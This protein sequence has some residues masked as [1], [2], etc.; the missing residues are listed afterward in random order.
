[1][2]K[3]IAGP[4][5]IPSAVANLYTPPN[6]AVYTVIN[7]I[8]VDNITGGAVAFSM[9]IGATGASAS[10]TQLFASQSVPANSAFDYWCKLKM[11]STDFLTAND[12]NGAALVVIIEGSYEAV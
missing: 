2:L 12:G 9:Y 8:H 10:G 4:A 1:M 7:H 6:A 3:R 5:F 11:L